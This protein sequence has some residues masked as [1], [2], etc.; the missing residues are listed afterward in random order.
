L[1]SPGL[2]I[3]SISSTIFNPVS[4]ITLPGVI[5]TR[6]LNFVFQNLADKEK[7]NGV[8]KEIFSFSLYLA[9]YLSIIVSTSFLPSLVFKLNLVSVNLSFK[10][11]VLYNTCS[12]LFFKIFVISNQL[13]VA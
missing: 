1:P 6:S 7:F 4:S 13:V 11:D 12:I 2:I 10:L 9:L 5:N 8:E 3:S